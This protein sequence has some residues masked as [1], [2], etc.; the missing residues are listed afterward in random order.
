DKEVGKASGTPIHGSPMDLGSGTLLPEKKLLIFILDRLQKKDV[1][2]VF[3]EPVDPN[4][5]PDY[6]DVIKEPMDFG[7]VRKKLD[8]G[9]YKKLEEL[10]ADVFL[11]CSN[12]MQYN[13]SDTVYYRQ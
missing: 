9:I 7:T 4:E 5:L 2:G 13:A 12:A 3:S 8:N 10:E 11:I 6:F 1:Y